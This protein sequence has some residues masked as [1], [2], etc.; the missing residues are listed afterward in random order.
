MERARVLQHRGAAQPRHKFRRTDRHPGVAAQ[1]LPAFAQGRAP[2][3][4]QHDKTAESY[5]TAVTL[6]SLLMWA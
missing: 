4:A 2:L 5:Q 6:A 1:E 3:A